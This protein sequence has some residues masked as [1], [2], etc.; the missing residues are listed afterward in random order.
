MGDGRRIK[1]RNSEPKSEPSPLAPRDFLVDNEET[2]EYP[3]VAGS[4]AEETLLFEL[5]TPYPFPRELEHIA[6]CPPKT[7]EQWQGFSFFQ[8][9]DAFSTILPLLIQ[10]A[11]LSAL[12]HFYK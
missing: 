4:P 3:L 9:E 5:D 8:S 2:R 11:P 12:P 6:L 1:Q 10:S 7:T